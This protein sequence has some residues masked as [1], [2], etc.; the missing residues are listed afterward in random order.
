[1]ASLITPTKPGSQQIPITGGSSGNS[2]PATSM[3]DAR[4]TSRLEDSPSTPTSSINGRKNRSRL[5]H[6]FG[7]LFGKKDPGSPRSGSTL[8]LSPSSAQEES[9]LDH[10]KNGIWELTDPCE[11]KDGFMDVVAIHGLQGDWKSTWEDD[12]KNWLRDFLPTQVQK[13]RVLSFGYDSRVAFSTSTPDLRDLSTKLLN[14]LEIKRDTPQEKRRPILFI[15]HSLGGIVLK[16]AMIIANERTGLHSWFLEHIKGVVFMGTPHLG[17]M[18]ANWALFFAN[19]LK[20]TIGQTTNTALLNALKVKSDK[21]TEICHQFPERAT[22]LKILSF[23]E[24]VICTGLNHRIVERE[25]SILGRENERVA[26]V[27]ADHI[28][29]CKFAQKQSQKYQG[30]FGLVRNLIKDIREDDVSPKDSIQLDPKDSRE[31]LASLFDTQ[32]S[33]RASAGTRVEGTCQW[34][35]TNPEFSLWNLSNDDNPDDTASSLLWVTGA[36][37]TGKSILTTFVADQL[38]RS[39][40]GASISTFSFDN[41]KR[42]I[43]TLLRSVLHNLLSSNPRLL[44]HVAKEWQ[45]KGKSFSTNWETLCEIWSQCCLD[46]DRADIIWVIDALDECDDG[47]IRFLEQLAKV[48]RTL[49][50]VGNTSTFKV[51]FTSRLEKDIQGALSGIRPLRINLDDEVGNLTL[52][53]TKV[54]D[55]GIEDLTNEEII[56]SHK[57]GLLKQRLLK[58]SD[59]TFLWVTL[60]LGLLR[61]SDLLLGDWESIL[62]DL[63]AGLDST[64]RQL[65]AQVPEI[66]RPSAKVVLQLIMAANKPLSVREMN[67]LLTVQEGYSREQDLRPLFDTSSRRIQKLYGSFVRII[68]T[69]NEDRDKHVHFVHKSAS[70]FLLA[71]NLN[72]SESQGELAPIWYAMDQVVAHAEIAKRCIWVLK[73]IGTSSKSLEKWQGHSDFDF[74]VFVLNFRNDHHMYDYAAVNWASHLQMSE[75]IMTDDIMSHSLHLYK[76]S[77]IYTT[78][79]QIFWALQ[80]LPQPHNY[81]AFHMTAYN[82]HAKLLNKL[83]DDDGDKTTKDSKSEGGDAIIH[84]AADRGHPKVIGVL[85]NHRTDFT[86]RDKIGLTALDRAVKANHP[87][88]VVALLEAGSSVDSRKQDGSTAL[89]LAASE[90][91]C[92]MIDL[93]VER[94]ATIQATNKQ[95]KTA[96]DIAFNKGHGEAHQ[97]LQNHQVDHGVTSLDQAIIE[98]NLSEVQSLIDS[99]AEFTSMD[100]INSSLLHLAA[101]ENHLDIVKFLLERNVG[102]H[103]EDENGLTA[104]HEAAKRGRTKIVEL[105][106]EYGANIDAKSKDESTP[107]HEAASGGNEEVVQLLLQ[108]KESEIQRVNATNDDGKTALYQAAALGYHLVVQSLISRGASTEIM[109]RTDRSPLHEASSNGHIEVLLELFKSSSI[110]VDCIDLR[111]ATPLTL[112]ARGTS[113][114]HGQVVKLLLEKGANP[115]WAERDR[116]TPIFLAAESG[117]ITSLEYILKK[118]VNPDER[119]TSRHTPLGTAA[120]KNHE[121]AVLLLLDNNAKDVAQNSSRRPPLSWSSEHGHLRAV[122]RLLTF[123]E[124]DVN[125][126]G[127]EERRTPLSYAAANGHLAVIRYLIQTANP[128]IDYTDR[129]DRTPLSW[130]AEGG[131]TGVASLLLENGADQCARDSEGRAPISWAAMKGSFQLLKAMTSRKGYAPASAITNNG[132]TLLALACENGHEIIVQFLLSRNKNHLNRASKDGF[133]PLHL[134]AA[135]GHDKIVDYVLS[136]D[137]I[138][139][140]L[141]SKKGY[142]AFSSAVRGGHFQ[143]AKNLIGFD[144]TVL[145]TETNEQQPPLLIAVGHGHSDI[146]S[147][148]LSKGAD[149]NFQNQQQETPI[150]VAAVK[151]DLVTVNVLLSDSRVQIDLERTN[152]TGMTPL[153]AAASLGHLSIVRRLVKHA[154]EHGL[155]SVIKQKDHQSFSPLSAAVRGGHPGIVE[156][157]L[158]REEYDPTEYNNKKGTILTLSLCSMNREVID[159]ILSRRSELDIPDKTLGR[160]P[161]L[162]AASLGDEDTI[163]FLLSECNVNGNATDFE[164]STATYLAAKGGH[165][166]ALKLLLENGIGDINAPESI[167]GSTPLIIAAKKGRLNILELLLQQEGIQVNQ[168]DNHGCTAFLWAAIEGHE[169]LVRKLSEVKRVKCGVRDFK[170]RSALSWASEKG[171]SRIVQILIDL[172]PEGIHDVD[173]YGSNPLWHAASFGWIYILENLLRWGSSSTTASGPHRRTPLMQACDAGY[174]SVVE[175]LCE[176]KDPGIDIK[177]VYGYTSLSL[178][179]KSGH[180]QI[181]TYLLNNGADPNTRARKSGRTPLMESAMVGSLNVFRALTAWEKIDINLQNDAGRTALWFALNYRKPGYNEMVYI[182]LRKNAHTDVADLEGTNYLMLTTEIIPSLPM[183]EPILQQLLDLGKIDPGATEP[184][185]GATALMKAVMQGSAVTVKQLL[186]HPTAHVNPEQANF[187]NI[188]PLAIAAITGYSTIIQM[189]LDCKVTVDSY[190]LLTRQTPLML[191]AMH[192]Q[193]LAVDQL[194]AAGANVNAMDKIRATPLFGAATFGCCRTI[195]R[196]LENGAIPEARSKTGST[197]LHV[198]AK[199]GHTPSV[200]LLAEKIPV[201]VRDRQGRTP[202]SYAA[203]AKQD[204]VVRYLLS[205][206]K[207]SEFEVNDSQNKTPLTWATVGGSVEIVSLL[208]N[209]GAKKDI[210]D[211]NGRSLVS[212]AAEKGHL[213]V[214]HYLILEGSSIDT[215]DN[216]GRAALSW[217][218]GEG[219]LSVVRCLLDNGADPNQRD[220]KGQQPQIYATNNEKKQVVELLRNYSSIGSIG[221]RRSSSIAA[222]R[223]SLTAGTRNSSI[224]AK[225]RT[226]PELPR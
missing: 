124:V 207:G 20:A 11:D 203:E 121:E 105:L 152:N 73:L 70:E 179:A 137:G 172:D 136:L 51:F 173:I 131:H 134:A 122:K 4:P 60:I 15:C 113:P 86:I 159:M 222:G 138:K 89:H 189:L 213:A 53:I 108:Q 21:L 23:Y 218:A 48:V 35:L 219:H 93:L 50:S 129:N 81:S 153:L 171:Y 114:S 87:K 145:D 156:F 158:K 184:S 175:R 132:K 19:L 63:P 8:V 161:L 211:R 120:A 198:A 142:T 169:F 135:N 128:N 96:A 34:I 127:N 188:T 183:N 69:G 150:F 126:S 217:A 110:D 204:N 5:S 151:G 205:L 182:L 65:L 208:L 66:Q 77:G 225:R 177:D 147:F 68:D 58:E 112:A 59:K 22:K 72:K 3:S 210:L 97:R 39:L 166:L 178:A 85:K 199:K 67:L 185:E 57:A 74:D 155:K 100:N 186:E 167:E 17:S 223:N 1:M 103:I 160:T 216:A 75:T 43:E 192:G 162:W 2:N 118:K 42:P 195:R 99:G 130:A 201:T 180:E 212:H 170:R 44:P 140:H 111:G 165:E 54:I 94:G 157:L 37:G 133:S 125:F 197:A 45:V 109:D 28:S 200:R 187:I 14:A 79:S 61:T 12:S 220:K 10:E 194:M 32:V 174:F 144:P 76:N 163:K 40:P 91:N 117:N 38:R 64:Y 47:R 191:A 104:L 176:K 6:R 119:N 46:L 106:L 139:V 62:R 9:I 123:K 24:L 221:S 209:R 98:G 25:S 224:A 49:Q 56:P 164:D 30:V 84:I 143:V 55:R 190:T 101:R 181:V 18:D 78:W 29:M 82:G 90:G 36:P 27:D 107:L 149:A 214:M 154:T 92:E 26:G 168:Q 71:E 148:L 16:Q 141:P 52:D 88:T 193:S 115:R 146:V 116:S 80:L 13:L 83:L 7:S 41:G 33:N 102:T 202:M 226:L 206:F 95:G 215:Q 31:I 196:L